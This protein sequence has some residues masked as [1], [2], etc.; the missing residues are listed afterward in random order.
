M[1]RTQDY[2][3]WKEQSLHIGQA[4]F[5]KIELVMQVYRKSHNANTRAS[6]QKA[7]KITTAEGSN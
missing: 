3:H 2:Q 4:T 6:N 1:V 5:L 7:I